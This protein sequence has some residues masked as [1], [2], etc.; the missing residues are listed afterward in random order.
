MVYGVRPIT[1]E[2]HDSSDEI[3]KELDAL[4]QEKSQ[5]KLNDKVIVLAGMPMAKMG[6]TNVMKLHRVGELR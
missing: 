6:P 3:L 1:I 5:L 2:A 4:L